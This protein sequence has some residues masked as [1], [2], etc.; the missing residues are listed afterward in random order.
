MN[1]NEFEQF[2]S[3]NGKDILRFCR[4]VSCDKEING[5]EDYILNES[6]KATIRK[7]VS[8]L[9][10]KYRIPIHMMILL[11]QITNC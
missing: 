9:P 2:V 4:I 5:P 3:D 1:D 7:V 10:E 8:G 11:M 6:E